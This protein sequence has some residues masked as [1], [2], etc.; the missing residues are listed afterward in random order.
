MKLQYLLFA[1]LISIGG[2]QAQTKLTAYGGTFLKGS[3]MLGEFNLMIGGKGAIV[4]NDQFAFGAFGNGLVKSFDLENAT[5]GLTGLETSYGYGGLFVEYIQHFDS[6]ISLSIPVHFGIGGVKIKE[7]DSGNKV[8]SSRLLTLEPELHL[9]FQIK[10]FTSIS[11][12]GGYRWA[13]T[14]DL[15][16]VS[17]KD[18][19]G[20]T[21]GIMF[22]SGLY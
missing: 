7:E 9:N 8:E 4:V 16:N 11:L 1:F 3:E 21:Y 15:I 2:I 5:E 14:K 10:E 22:R 20:L 6:P 19:S 18:M 13:D 12:F 17:N